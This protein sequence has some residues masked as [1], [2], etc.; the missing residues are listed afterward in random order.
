MARVIICDD[1]ATAAEDLAAALRAVK[2]QAST[3][4]H[5]MDVL[6]EAADGRFDLVAF[7]LDRAGF[8]SEHAIEAMQEVAPHVSIIGFHRRPSEFLRL[9]SNARLSAVLPRPVSP[10]IFLYAVARALE[11][12]RAGSS[13]LQS[14]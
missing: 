10:T 9:P 3:C 5:L 13:A 8:S 6:R 1:D 14:A 12:Q 7:T 2:H 11:S 4:S